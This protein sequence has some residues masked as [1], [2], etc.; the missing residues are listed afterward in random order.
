MGTEVTEKEIA[1]REDLRA[2]ETFTIDPEQAKDFD[3]ALSLEK[4]GGF[5]HLGVHIADVSH[6][7]KR[8]SEIDR[9]ARCRANSI[10]LPGQVLPMLPKALSNELCSLKPNV[11][12]LT[13]SVFMIFDSQGE[14]KDYRLTRSVICSQKRFTY[15]EA[16]GVLEGK[17]KSRHAKTLSLMSSLCELLKT[18]RMERGS[19]QMAL[20]QMQI[21]CDKK[22][23]AVAFHLEEY[24]LS[25]Q[26][27]EEFMLK[28]NE[29]VATHLFH[30]NKPLTY[31]IHEEPSPQETADFARFA[32][33]LGFPLAAKPTS[34]EIQKVLDR[35]RESSLGEYLTTAFIRTMKLA[36]YSVDNIGHFGLG[37]EHYTHFTSPIRRYIDL[38][39]HRLLFEKEQEEDLE[40]IAEKCSEKERLA[41]KVESEIA[42]L[43]KLR[44]LEKNRQESYEAIVTGLSSKGL[45]FSIPTLFLEAF[46]PF[47]ALEDDYYQYDPKRAQLLGRYSGKTY[48]VGDKIT[49]ELLYIDLITCTSEWQVREEKRVSRKKKR[50]RDART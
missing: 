16:R 33:S 17:K 25:H 41:A 31:R 13:V 46:L 23:E 42:L 27:V 9:E 48:Q 19:I 6:Y 29:V 39:I 10:Y 5:Y 20:P 50:K 4:R 43:K 44:F 47:N 3:D 24:D 34:S 11:N 26:L 12:R 36:H 38:V 7:V 28:A 14:L 40:E 8:G 18:K 32:T 22:G 35:S 45:L 2:L 30:E 1:S 49:V 15:G 37:L 21:E